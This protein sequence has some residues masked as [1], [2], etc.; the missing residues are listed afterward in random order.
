[1]MTVVPVNGSRFVVAGFN[2]S[3][4]AAVPTWTHRTAIVAKSGLRELTDT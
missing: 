4:A 2:E 3:L 1:M